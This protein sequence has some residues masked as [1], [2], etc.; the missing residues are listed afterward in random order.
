M[1]NRWV[2]ISSVLLAVCIL[3]SGC[4]PKT[5]VA[6]FSADVQKGRAPLK[7]FFKDEST[8][9]KSVIVDTEILKQ[10]ILPST[11]PK[12]SIIN[13]WSWDFGDGEVSNAQHTFH[14]Y[15][16]P[17]EYT[18]SLVVETNKGKKDSVFRKNYITVS[19]NEGEGEGETSEGETEEGETEGEQTEGEAQEGETQYCD[20]DT[21]PPIITLVGT[22][23]VTIDCGGI[24]SDAGA[25]AADACDGILTAS[26]VTINPVNTVIA[27]TYTVRYT[28]S[29]TSGNAAVEVTR[30]VTVANNCE[31]FGD[32]MTIMLPGDVPLV[33]MQI[34]A[35]SF[36]MG[37]YP[38]EQD[39][40]GDEEP[41]HEVTISGGFWIGKYE[42]TQQQWLAVMDSWPASIFTESNGAGDVYPA[43][44]VSWDDVKEFI[45]ALNTHIQ[46]TEQGPL[47]VRLPS[48]AEWEYAARAGT[49][50][51]FYWGDDPTYTL[52]QDY[53]WY[54][55]NSSGITQPVGQK[56]QN[57]FALFD[58]AGNVWEWC[59]DDYHDSY[60]GA[61]A[62][63]SAWTDSPRSIERV[64]RG[65]AKN[66]KNWGCR[67]ANR[68]KSANN[69]YG[70]IGFRVAADVT[71]P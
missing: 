4:K 38:G 13:S 51:R 35:G 17:G 6:A 55:D 22:P 46:N 47:T 16:D 21:T 49:A 41:Q 45:G 30:S 67:L 57:A 8:I 69:G 28:V 27:G 66:E 3:A 14:T 40:G 12:K 36:M 29:D 20:P 37:R 32:E 5:P 25:T 33:L 34:P 68:L 31:S 65:G 26:I 24:Y 71:A 42:I 52:I 1:K 70:N 58:M 7:V 56:Q 15:N 9:E 61:P 63:G 11:E 50:T 53:A 23:A 44:S 62:D 60:T 59:E 2:I 64:V 39:S 18:V 48:E 54:T 43:Y 10:S 19:A